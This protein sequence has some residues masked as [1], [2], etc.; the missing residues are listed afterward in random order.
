VGAA[1]YPAQAGGGAYQTPSRNRLGGYVFGTRKWTPKLGGGDDWG[2]IRAGVRAAGAV[3]G[4][5][6]GDAG[7][8]GYFVGVA[9]AQ[10]RERGIGPPTGYK[11][12]RWRPPGRRNCFKELTDTSAGF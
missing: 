3:G 11:N 12:G 10:R 1:D 4:R 6:G 2:G 9:G 8:P 5:R 7:R